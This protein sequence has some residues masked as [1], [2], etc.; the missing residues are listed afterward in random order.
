[1]ITI[2]VVSIIVLVLSA[3][4]FVYCVSHDNEMDTVCILG[5]C[6]SIFP[7]AIVIVIGTLI[8]WTDESHKEHYMKERQ[9]LIEEIQNADNPYM[10]YQVAE[11]VYDFNNWHGDDKDLYIDFNEYTKDKGEL[12]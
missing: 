12:K 1:M 3:I 5:M 7:I 2:L 6:L 11:R 9:V 8:G 10:L 4:G